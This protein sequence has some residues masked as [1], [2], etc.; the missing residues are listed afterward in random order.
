MEIKEAS[1][2]ITRRRNSIPSPETSYMEENMQSTKKQVITC[3]KDT[4]APPGVIQV[5]SG[6]QK[7][8]HAPLGAQKYTCASTDESRARPCVLF[9]KITAFW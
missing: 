5:P 4:G 8:T 7:Y 2:D 6:A 1:K 9:W 3:E